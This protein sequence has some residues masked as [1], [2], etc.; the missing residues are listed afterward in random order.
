MIRAARIGAGLAVAA[1]VVGL[2]AVDRFAGTVWGTA[3]LVI[4][5]GVLSLRELFAMLRGA[6]IEA[7]ERP[8]LA[9]L[10]ASL[11]LRA[12]EE[13]LGLAP[14]EARELSLAVLALGFVAPLALQV[15]RA[16]EEVTPRPEEV[17]RAAATAFGLGWIGLLATFLLELRMMRG[18]GGD[19]R[20]G[21][22]LAFLL[23][24]T[25]KVGDTMAYFVGRSVGRTKLSPVSPKKTWEGSVA[26]VCGSVATSV[27]I[28]SVFMGHDARLMA[29]FG[30]VADLAGQGGDL[31]ES[32]VK[33]ALGAKDSGSPFGEMGGFLDL[34]DAVLLAAPPAYLWAELLIARGA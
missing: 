23:V 18:P 16:R 8:A 28:G 7:H 30:L 5:C 17:R 15:A 10:A 11:A 21:L 27:V 20:T 19:L 31:V 1:A 4:A 9:A 12:A 26:S 24:A 3:A 22:E 32:W 2:F 29:V 13:P 33:R 6:G 25:V 14:K 34:A